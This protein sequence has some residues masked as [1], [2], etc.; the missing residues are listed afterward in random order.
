MS[1][2]FYDYLYCKEPEELFKEL[3]NLEDMS[4]QLI[5]LNYL[6][7]ARDMRRLVEY[8]RSARIRVE[9]L[10]E[11]LKPVMKAVEWYESNDIGK[12]SL[13]KA[14]EKYRGIGTVEV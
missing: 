3:G 9:V 11:Q 10:S 1:G 8:I 5:R 7:V 13:D 12:D 4:E 14:I 2:G 6:D